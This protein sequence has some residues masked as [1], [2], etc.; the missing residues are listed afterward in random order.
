M[1]DRRVV[2][3]RDT[4]DKGFGGGGGRLG[5]GILLGVGGDDFAGAVIG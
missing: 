1:Q 5:D 3:G 4:V 2:F